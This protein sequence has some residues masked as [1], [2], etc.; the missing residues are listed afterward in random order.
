M[1]I[2]DLTLS[3][4]HYHLGQQFAARQRG[5]TKDNTGGS[6]KYFFYLIVTVV[7][8]SLAVPITI[9]RNLTREQ[10]LQR[11]LQFA[12]RHRLS[13]LLGLSQV[14]MQWAGRR[15]SRQQEQTYQE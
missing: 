13:A 14:L 15:A 4:F 12:H 7:K 1:P 8:M 2:L 9:A 5:I 3:F 11:V 6:H 10:A